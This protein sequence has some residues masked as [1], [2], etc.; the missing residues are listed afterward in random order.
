MS[1]HKV[2]MVDNYDSFTTNTC[3]TA[4]LGA[5]LRNRNDAITL[6]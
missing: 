1:A 2:L 6:D 3:S 4:E 5:I